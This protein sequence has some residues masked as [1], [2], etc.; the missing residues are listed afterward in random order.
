M[1]ALADE[2]IDHIGESIFRG[3]L[4]DELSKV[5]KTKPSTE[6]VKKFYPTT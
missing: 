5:Q 2:S 3:R 4:F 6:P 1:F